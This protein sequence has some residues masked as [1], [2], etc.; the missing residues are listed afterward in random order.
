MAEQSSVPGTRRFT[1]RSATYIGFFTFA[2]RVVERGGAFGQIAIVASLYGSSF[3]ADRYFIASIV[4]LIIGAIAAEALSAN[5]LPALVRRGPESGSLVAAG[6]WLAAGAL[7]LVTAAYLGVAAIVVRHAAPAGSS[8][9]GVWYAFAPVGL[10]MGLSGYLTGVLTFHERYVWPP[11]RSA[12]ASL[13]GFLLMLAVSFWTHSL[14]WVAVAV[15]GGYALS[16]SA[17]LGEIRRVAG[18]AALGLPTKPTLRRAARLAGGLVSPVLGGVLGGQVFVLLERALASTL[19]VGAVAT[20]SYA[21]GVAFTPVIVAQAIALG[22]YP[23]MVRAYEAHDLDH[24][25]GSIVRGLRL[26]IFLGAGLASFFALFG[27]DTIDVLLRRG[28]LDVHAADRSGTLLAAF[29][30]ALFGNMLLVLLARVFYAIGYFRAVVW[31]QVWA[32]VVYAAIALPLR[33]VWGTTGLAISFGAAET[34][35]AVYALVLAGRHV[36]LSLRLVVS[37]SVLPALARCVAVAVALAGAKL[38]LASGAPGAQPLVRVVV[39]LVFGSLVGLAALWS[40]A[41]PELGPLKRRMRGL[42]PR[43]ATP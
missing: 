33:G 16:F 18:G 6:F 21:R 12:I 23:G 9:L 25:R 8:D 13:G 43:R 14:L 2:A 29:A 26:T 10:L 20:L 36:E 22:V 32:L 39:A 41:W 37:S 4:P 19:G 34:S 27:A 30:L 15:T 31:T 17:L 40:S 24:V 38:A 11:F 5:I 35:A 7:V 1:S 28:A 3:I 42:Y